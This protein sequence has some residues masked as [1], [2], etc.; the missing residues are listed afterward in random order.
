MQEDNEADAIEI[1]DEWWEKLTAM[2]FVSCKLSK[3]FVIDL[4]TRGMTWGGADRVN[5]REPRRIARSCRQRTAGGARSPAASPDSVGR[6]VQ[7]LSVAQPRM[8][9]D[10]ATA[11]ARHGGRV[12]RAGPRTGRQKKARA[13]RDTDGTRAEC[14]G[15]WGHSLALAQ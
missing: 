5:S 10:S 8:L 11:A 7:K 12:P 14:D 9:V 4:A 2:P 15:Q 3:C 13:A 6:P 1:S